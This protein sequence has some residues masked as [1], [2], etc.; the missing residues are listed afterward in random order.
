[1]VGWIEKAVKWFSD[2]LSPVENTT[3]ELLAASRAGRNFGE[4]LAAG[5][6]L[7]TKPLQW[8]MDSIK[9]IMDNIPTIEKTADAIMPQQHRQQIQ[10]TAA[11][12]YADP[13][14]GMLTDNIASTKEMPLVKKWSGGYAGNGGNR[15]TP[16]T[17]DG[18][19]H[20]QRCPRT[21]R[22]RHCPHD[23]PRNAAH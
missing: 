5:I 22:T 10:K 7:V 4:W 11:L 16:A 15:A 9:W 3:V 13:T 18:E 12:A 14:G 21:G 8:V 2:L 19:Y 6:D 17:D 23:R 1:M 20:H